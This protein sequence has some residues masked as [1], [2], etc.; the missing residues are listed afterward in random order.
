MELPE[1]NQ[2]DA[3]ILPSGHRIYPS[4]KLEKWFVWL[5]D[6]FEELENKVRVG[7]GQII[8][9]DSSLMYFNTPEEALTFIG[10]LDI[11]K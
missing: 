5:F 4:K 3:Y 6:H 1:K 9:T 7:V 10:D 11:G 8:M 2:W